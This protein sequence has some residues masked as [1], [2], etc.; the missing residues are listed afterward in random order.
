MARDEFRDDQIYFLH[1]Y[2]NADRE[3][4]QPV[5]D[6][7]GL[8]PLL[9]RTARQYDRTWPTHSGTADCATACDVELVGAAHNRWGTQ[10]FSKL[11]GDW[12]L[13]LWNP[14]DRTLILARDFLGTRSLYYSTNAGSVSWSSLLDPLILAGTS[15]PFLDEEYIAGWFARFPATHLTPYVRVRAVPPSSFVLFRNGRQTSAKP[16]GVRPGKTDRLQKLGRL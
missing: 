12:A 5:P 1:R 8:R 9:G 16:L 7:S 6:G 11:I 4:R 13:S 14:N 2:S 15:P 3:I 10:T